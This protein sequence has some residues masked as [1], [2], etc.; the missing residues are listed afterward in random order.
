MVSL[1]TTIYFAGVMV[2][3]IVFGTLADRFG[4]KPLML[5]ALY[6]HVFVGTALAFAN[7]YTMFV[8]LRFILGFLLQVSYILFISKLVDNCIT[9]NNN[10]IF[11]VLLYM[12][13]LLIHYVW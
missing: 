12:M 11:C 9:T 7:S 2:G 6:G 3:G 5:A 13:L 4:R 10:V 8:I 1:A